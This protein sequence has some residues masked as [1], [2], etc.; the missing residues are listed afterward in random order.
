MKKF[1][2]TDLS[3]PVVV[4]PAH[5]TCEADL[6]QAI[7]VLLLR[8]FLQLPE[9]NRLESKLLILDIEYAHFEVES[10]QL[11]LSEI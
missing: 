4:E 7:I 2:L 1:V 8:L 3:L 6:A 11:S 9:A 10:Q 5:R